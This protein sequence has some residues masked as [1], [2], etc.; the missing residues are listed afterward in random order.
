MLEVRYVPSKYKMLV[1]NWDD[2]APDFALN[3]EIAR[4]VKTFAYLGTVI[5]Q[6]T[7]ASKKQT[8]FLRIRDTWVADETFD[9]LW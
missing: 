6:G 2:R 5:Y 4:V 1:Q 3:N 7:A 8:L 9:R